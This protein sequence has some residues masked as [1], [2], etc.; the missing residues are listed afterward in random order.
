M[1]SSSRLGKF[2]A[3]IGLSNAKE[4][5]VSFLLKNEYFLLPKAS[6]ETPLAYIKQ[7]HLHQAQASLQQQVTHARFSVL[8]KIAKK[9]LS[10][11]IQHKIKVYI[12]RA[13][14]Q[15]QEP[16]EV[17]KYKDASFPKVGYDA[18]WEM[19]FNKV[20]APFYRRFINHCDLKW[21]SGQGLIVLGGLEEPALVIA[22][23]NSALSMDPDSFY[24]LLCSEKTSLSSSLKKKNNFCLVFD[25][26]S[27]KNK[28]CAENRVLDEYSLV[29]H[30]FVLHPGQEVVSNRD[31]A[32]AIIQHHQC[33][34]ARAID[35]EKQFIYL[36]VEVENLVDAYHLLYELDQWAA[37][38]TN[39][40]AVF[41]CPFREKVSTE[42]TQKLEHTV[43]LTNLSEK[44]KA[45]L[46]HESMV[47]IGLG[48]GVALLE[49]ATLA[50][51]LGKQVL[52]EH[53]EDSVAIFTDHVDYIQRQQC[54]SFI[55]KLQACYKYKE[56]KTKQTKLADY[57]RKK[58]SV[59]GVSR[60]IH[61]LIWF[62]YLD[63]KKQKEGIKQ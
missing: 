50:G 60:L 5:K 8:K 44:K 16:V 25:S 2:F 47:Y 17:Q 52:V 61:Q 49:R 41:I 38:H 7:M 10:P 28:V 33:G 59:E 43:F 19:Y 31:Y 20:V 36:D 6:I 39:A 53:S 42:I 3:S 63:W 29:I 34:L 56:S 27:T 48:S 24:C 13:K 35:V 32:S 46:I 1:F 23:L 45:A 26:Y 62:K 11:A 37:K 40:Q 30:P 55:K 15:N 14:G 12:Y 58:F 54:R 21:W 4:K 51:W 57:L 22:E 18:V 9:V